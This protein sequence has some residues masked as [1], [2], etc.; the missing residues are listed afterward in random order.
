LCNEK[1]KTRG[2]DSRYLNS[3][4]RTKLLESAKL[5]A[6]QSKSGANLRN[7]IKTAITKS[8]R[9]LK[10]KK[11]PKQSNSEKSTTRVEPPY[12][13]DFNAKPSNENVGKV[14]VTTSRQ[15]LPKTKES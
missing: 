8:E 13:K 15:P 6:E 7:Y 2:I 12:L 11:K 14:F 1:A 10:M 4:R 3:V 9:F 5:Q